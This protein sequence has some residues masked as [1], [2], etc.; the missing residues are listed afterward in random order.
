MMPMILKIRS[1][2]KNREKFSLWLPLF[3]IWIIV[4]PMIIIL[5]PFIAF[6]ALIM[7]PSGKSPLIFQSY[8]TIFRIIGCLSGFKMD[9]ESRNSTFFIILK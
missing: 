3:L 9:I 5:F 4:L 6:A 8:I 1:R 7:L 2:G